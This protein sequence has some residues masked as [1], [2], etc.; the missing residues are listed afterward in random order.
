M[1]T[2]FD[3]LTGAPIISE[4]ER[5]AALNRLRIRDPLTNLPEPAGGILLNGNVILDFAVDIPGTLPDANELGT[6]FTSLQP[7]Q[8][9][10]QL[11]LFESEFVEL[12]TADGILLLTAEPGSDASTNTLNNALQLPIAAVQEFTISTRL[13]N[14]PTESTA[15]GEKLGGRLSGNEP[16]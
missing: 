9:D 12:D 14:L 1:G 15:E 6:G 13:R 2:I 3:P 16:G 10:S 8:T 4:E 5:A 7:N 11:D